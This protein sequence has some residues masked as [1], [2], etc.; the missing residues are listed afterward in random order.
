MDSRKNKGGSKAGEG[1][2]AERQVVIKAYGVLASP[3]EVAHALKLLRV[4][5]AMVDNSLVAKSKSRHLSAEQ[6]AWPIILPSVTFCHRY[7]SPYAR[8]ILFICDSLSCLKTCNVKV[9]D[10]TDLV[11]SMRRALEYAVENPEDWHLVRK[12]PTM[13]DYVNAATKPSF[14]NH[15]QAAIY[16]ITPYDLRKE[17][18]ALLIGYLAGVEARSKLMAKLDSSHKLWELKEMMKDP[19]SGA[20]RQAVMQYKKEGNVE[21]VASQHKLQTFEILYIAGSSK[22]TIAGLK[23]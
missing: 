10:P 21:L 11:K 5:H 13:D 15:V 1:S 6:P 8:Q 20:L 2:S 18:A 3:L 9:L 4:S 17:V 7:R 12:E 14:L 19:M 23:K 22:K 16:K